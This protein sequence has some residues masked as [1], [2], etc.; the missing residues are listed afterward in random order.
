MS[1]ENTNH[2]CN[3]DCNHC[4]SYIPCFGPAGPAGATS[5]NQYLSLGASSGLV[6]LPNVQTPIA[7]DNINASN[8]GDIAATVTT[9]TVTLAPNHSYYVSYTVNT[10]GNGVNTGILST[11]LLLNGNNI[12]S[13]GTGNEGASFVSTSGGTVIK[14]GSSQAK[15]QLAASVPS[16]GTL[17]L[18]NADLSI[19]ELS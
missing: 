4:V 17:T 13:S 8:G 10:S 14:V 15:L 6:P 16:V 12:P 2:C 7:F 5:T 11:I 9:N 18:E 1:Y 3:T 19:V